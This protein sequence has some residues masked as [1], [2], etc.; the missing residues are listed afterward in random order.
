[1]IKSRL[2]K[3]ANA[4]AAHLARRHRPDYQIILFTGILL[5]LGLI[6]LFS[7][8]NARV[9]LI[10]ASSGS[11]LDQAHFMQKQVLYLGLGITA[12]MI[13]ATLPIKFWSSIASR[14]LLTGL[15]AC[16]LLFL[17]GLFMD[18]G[19]V[20]KSGGATRWFNMPFGTFQPAELLKFGMML[21]TA[22]FLARRIQQGRVNNAQ[23]TL[24]PLTLLLG[25]ALFFIV[26]LQK[27]MGTGITLTGIV[28][29]MLYLAGINRRYMLAGFFGL[30]SVGVLLIV[31][32]PHRMERVATFLNPS[33]AASE[34]EGYHIQQATIALGTGGFSG[35]GLGQSIQA[36][37]YVPEA[38]NDSI[39]AILGETFGFVGLVSV[40]CLFFGLLLRLLKTYNQVV[41]PTQQMLVAGVFGWIASHTVVNVG[42]MLGVFPLTG[43]TLPFLSFGG[44]SLLFIMIALGI[45]FHISRFTTHQAINQSNNG[46]S[47]NEDSRSRRG[48]GRTRYASTRSY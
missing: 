46:R 30:L 29:A 39:F 13:A 45:V 31:T 34:A 18:G 26:V 35:R 4:N 24:I 47:S 21:F 1:M 3:T 44:T 22:L 33:L 10:N 41:D 9:E 20:L 11:N 23:E 38:L 16:A 19:L 28:V 7:I 15:G 27:D 36:Y 37:G 6:L 8:S 48:V 40:M 25:V 12:F 43:V 42:A 32:S 5:L 2:N 17:L 14:V